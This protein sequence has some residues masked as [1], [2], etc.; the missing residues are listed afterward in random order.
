LLL[1]FQNEHG[2][3]VHF[4]FA[5]PC[6]VQV[7]KQQCAVMYLGRIVEMG[8]VNE[9][10]DN[11]I[12]PYTKALLSASPIPDPAIEKKRKRI[13]LS[14][15][16]PSPIIRPNGCFFNPRCPFRMEQC[17]KEYPQTKSIS[18]NHQVACYLVDKREV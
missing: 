7:H 1:D 15:N 9:V 4:Y 3:H 5:Q 11:P 16:V 12:H 14:G 2:S 10:F 6:I 8:D 13:I 18:G 17:D